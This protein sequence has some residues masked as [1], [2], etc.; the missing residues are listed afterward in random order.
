MRLL[1]LVFLFA[2]F[3]AA[4][5]DYGRERRWAAEVVPNLVVGDAVQ[6]KLPSGRE[7]LGLY[8]ENKTARNALL[9]VHGIGV[10]P[11]HSVIGVLRV[12]L[13]E[14]GYATLSIQMPVLE[15]NAAPDDYTAVFPEAA[16]RIQ[17]GADWLAAKGFARPV[18][19]SHSLGSRMANVYF[20]RTADAPFAAWICMG[21]SGDFGR[22][23][24]VGI[25]VLDL[26]GEND[27]PGVSR[28]DWRRRLKLNAVP[29]SAQAMIAGADHF[30]VGRETQLE[31]A[32]REFLERLK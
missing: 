21:L 23:G 17:A 15:S 11:D 28:A 24:N 14:M 13:S 8:V 2:A 29:G 31:A 5:Q 19:L 3:G 30:Y 1:L 18:L 9:L 7:F 26:Y 25:P 27:L 16:A 32:I 20:E 4:A 22:M 6:L 10:H 12:A